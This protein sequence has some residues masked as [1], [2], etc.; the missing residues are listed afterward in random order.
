[1]LKRH[2]NIICKRFFR[3]KK[4]IKVILSN[5]IRIKVIIYIEDPKEA[6]SVNYIH[7]KEDIKVEKTT[8]IDIITTSYP[9]K[10][11]A[12]SAIN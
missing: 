2:N 5:I 12:M 1:M 7:I 10:S 3:S 9:I 8:I 4:I 11:D 6:F